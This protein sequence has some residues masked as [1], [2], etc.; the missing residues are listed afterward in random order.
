MEMSMLKVIKNYFFVLLFPTLFLN[1]L[2]S[3]N[4]DGILIMVNI[5]ANIVATHSKLFGNSM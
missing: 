1:N 2:L 4:K 5:Q 3:L